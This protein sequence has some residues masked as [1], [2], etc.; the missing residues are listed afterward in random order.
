MTHRES[1]ERRFAAWR[2][3]DAL[4]A[5]AHFAEDGT[6]REASREPILGRPAIV[7]HFTK[8][9]RDGPRWEF[10]TDDVIVER[11]RAAVRYRFA[12]VSPEGARVERSGCALV[13]FR[14]GTI[15]E[16]REYEG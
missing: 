5:G 11:D 9:F 8:F 4:V 10:H 16:W 12:I 6:Y 14:D 2:G 13:T 7:T 15:L 1:L 3:G